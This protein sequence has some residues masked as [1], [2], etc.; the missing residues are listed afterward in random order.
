[1]TTPE[2]CNKSPKKNAFSNSASTPFERDHD[3]ALL[4]GPRETVQKKAAILD[5]DQE[6]EPLI[7]KTKE[8]AV[9]AVAAVSFQW[10]STPKSKKDKTTYRPIPS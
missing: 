8:K 2:K 1:M 4:Q 10:T 6:K 7:M 5:Q 3:L 9:K